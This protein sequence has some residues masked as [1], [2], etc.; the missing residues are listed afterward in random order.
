M[1]GPTD[2]MLHLRH[3]LVQIAP[4]PF[5][6]ACRA[7]GLLQLIDSHHPQGGVTDLGRVEDC[8]RKQGSPQM[9]PP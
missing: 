6:G 8:V 3:N 9:L 2:E 1:P 7:D 4:A 5:V